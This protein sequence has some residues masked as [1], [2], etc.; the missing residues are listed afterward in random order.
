MSDVTMSV[1][2]NH[3]Y[4]DE[5][6]ELRKLCNESAEIFWTCPGCET[7]IK[8]KSKQVLDTLDGKN[9]LVFA[10]TCGDTAEL[11]HVDPIPVDEVRP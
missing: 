5:R 4:Y 2:E 10:C 6:K 7:R 8:T 9:L 11:S 1:S 3:V